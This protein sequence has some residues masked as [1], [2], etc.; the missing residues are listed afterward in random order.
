MDIAARITAKGQITIPRAVRQAL[1]LET[2]DAVIFHLQN[3]HAVL[4]KTPHFLELAGSIS[5]PAERRNV[6]WDDVLAQT[7]ADRA[8]R[9]R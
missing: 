2:G 4:S 9:H 7:R 1:G 5:V 8:S 3:G 6:A